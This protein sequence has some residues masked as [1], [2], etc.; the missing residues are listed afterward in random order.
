ME[1]TEFYVE[2]RKRLKMS[3]RSSLN[4]KSHIVNRKLNRSLRLYFGLWTL[5]S[6]F[7]PVNNFQSFSV[8]SV[9]HRGVARPYSTCFP[10]SDGYN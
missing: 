3:E 7:L 10:E 8:K 9:T 1:A 4:R 5:T 6:D 2:N